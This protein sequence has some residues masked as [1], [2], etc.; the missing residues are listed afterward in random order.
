MLEGIKRQISQNNLILFIGAGVPATLGLPT[1]ADLIS[2]IAIDLGYDPRLFRQY[3]DFLALAEYYSISKGHIGELRDWMSR[4][5]DITS[6]RIR[7]SSIY[8]NITKLKCN[9]IY[10]TNYDHTI[11]KALELYVKPYKRIVDV[12][13][14]VGIDQTITQVVK[15]HGDVVMEDSIVL[16]E[17]DY[18]RRLDFESPMDIKLRSDILG[19]S[20]L[21]IGYSLSDINIRL[22][23]Y[24]LNALWKMTNQSKH[25]PKS[26]I[27][28][29]TPNPIQKEIFEHRGIVP[30]IGS[31]IDPAR[32]LELFL[33]ELVS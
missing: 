25:R 30:V 11:E 18:F 16:T 23:I 19:R 21:F 10:T 14:L 22:L 27:F 26:Y 8:E 17:S 29:P 9:I 31:E 32:S 3:G 5:W 12:G 7:E 33:S 4:K 28:L 6:E 24:K 1:W 2:Q 15:F 20:I 13:D